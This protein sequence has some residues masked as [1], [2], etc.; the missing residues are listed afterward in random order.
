[1]HEE[2]PG[3]T[4][5]YTAKIAHLARHKD[6]V[7]ELQALGNLFVVS[8]VES[9]SDEVLARLDKGHTR[10]DALDVFRHF[11]DIDL[12]LRPSLV[13]FTPWETLDSYR[14][15]LDTFACEGLVGQIDAV[16]FSIRLLVPPG[17]WLADDPAMTPYI[18]GLDAAEF[19][20][21]WSHPDRRMDALHARVATRR[22]ARRRERRAPAR[23]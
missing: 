5:D 13:P 18:D 21:R 1:V 2:H 15:L 4:F 11:R 20:H 7:E 19:T 16:Q 22:R 6:V 17:S 23:W 14:D 12:T 9:L 3:L 10:R 8:A